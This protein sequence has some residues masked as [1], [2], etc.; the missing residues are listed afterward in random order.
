[1][2]IR[3]FNQGIEYYIYNYYFSLAI[4]SVTFSRKIQKFSDQS[5]LNGRMMVLSENINNLINYSIFIIL[6]C[7]D[8]VIKMLII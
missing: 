1:M 3:T 5:S 6:N 8:S 2:N 7:N 4:H